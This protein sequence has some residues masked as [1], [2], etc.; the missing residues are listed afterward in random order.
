[1][2]P[3]LVFLLIAVGLLA[4]ELLVMQFS[5][6]WFLFFAIGA[7]ITSLILWVMPDLGW[8]AAWGMFFV[9]SLL[10]SAVLFPALK[11]WQAKP[12]PLSGNDAIGQKAKVVEPITQAKSGKVL[13]SGTEWPAQIE[14]GAENLGAGDTVVIRKLEGI[15]LI[16]SR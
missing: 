3:A 12:S 13:W 7:L 6:F 11:R 1:M 4:T 14:A 2:S 5:F 16:V 8:S 9:A 15:R 10:T